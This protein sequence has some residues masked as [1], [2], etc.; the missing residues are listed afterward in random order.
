MSIFNVDSIG[1]GGRSALLFAATDGKHRPASHPVYR[2][3]IEEPP[4]REPEK[5]RRDER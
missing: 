5:P 1:H 4:E 2:R 3:V